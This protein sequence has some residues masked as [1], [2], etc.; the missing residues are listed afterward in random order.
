MKLLLRQSHAE[1][2]VHQQ[3][4]QH[5]VTLF[6]LDW[7]QVL[8]AKLCPA[9]VCRLGKQNSG[10]CERLQPAEDSCISLSAD[11]VLFDDHSQT[12]LSCSMHTLQLPPL[13]R[14]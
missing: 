6:C 8:V 5:I 1:Q 4:L 10:L 14:F 7:D 2:P 12:E 13:P 11:N 3:L 9:S